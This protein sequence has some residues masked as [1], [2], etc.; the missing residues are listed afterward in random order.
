MEPLT[1]RR[2]ADEG[3]AR[4]A[5]GEIALASLRRARGLTQRQVG[6]AMGVPQPRVAQIEKQTDLYLSTLRG[7]VEAMG[8]QLAIV[9]TFPDATVVVS[10]PGALAEGVEIEAEWAALG[11]ERLSAT[12]VARAL[13]TRSL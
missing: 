2:R 11:L 5:D 13:D 12:E 4:E 10:G 7:Y 6:Q 9:A 1:E 3:D 8:G